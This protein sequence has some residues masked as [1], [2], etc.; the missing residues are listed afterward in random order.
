MRRGYVVRWLYNSFLTFAIFIHIIRFLGHNRRTADDKGDDKSDD[1]S[2]DDEKKTPEITAEMVHGFVHSLK[3]DM[4]ELTNQNKCIDLQQ[5]FRPVFV[6]FFK[7]NLYHRYKAVT[8]RRVLAEKGFDLKALE[9]IWEEKKK[10]RNTFFFNFFPITRMWLFPDRNIVYHSPSLT[11]L[12]CSFTRM[13]VGWFD[14]DHFRIGRNQGRTSSRIGRHFG[15]LLWPGEGANCTGGTESTTP[16]I[17][18]QE[19]IE[20]RESANAQ[21][22]IQSHRSEQQRCAGNSGLDHWFADQKPSPKPTALPGQTSAQ[23]II[24]HIVEPVDHPNTVSTC[25]R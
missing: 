3:Y 9:A 6:Q 20:Q 1:K 25:R 23:Q 10:V 16:S 13:S 15:Q 8:F 17:I 21:G 11:S 18:V 24:G 22:Q 4:N 5:T 19:T 7:T 12:W 14:R 2:E